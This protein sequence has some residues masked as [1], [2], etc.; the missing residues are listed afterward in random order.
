MH[1]VSKDN[2]VNWTKPS[3]L[4]EKPG[5]FTRHPVVILQDGSWMLPLTYITASA[6][7]KG[8]EAN[9]SPTEISRDKGATWQDCPTTGSQGKTQPSVVSLAPG[10]LLAFFRSRVRDFIFTSRSPA[11]PHP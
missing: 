7:D 3:L 5:A 6:I 8:S 4:F 2:G 10:R 1:L 11:I 9:Y